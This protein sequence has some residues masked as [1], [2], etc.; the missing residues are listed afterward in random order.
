M[1]HFGDAPGRMWMTQL[2]ISI[3]EVVVAHLRGLC[4][5][6]LLCLEALCLLMIHCTEEDIMTR[7]TA[8]LIWMTL[9]TGGL[10]WMT[11]STG[12]QATIC[13]VSGRQGTSMF[14]DGGMPTLGL[15]LGPWL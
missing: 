4:M 15:C 6:M 11:L 7:C 12:G 2:T 10:I 9:S 3:T 14:S 8:L 5:W 13:E 1:S